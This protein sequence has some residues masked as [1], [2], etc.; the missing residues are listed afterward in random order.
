MY[1]YANIVQLTLKAAERVGTIYNLSMIRSGER[2]YRLYEVQRTLEA[3][4]NF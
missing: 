2:R 4:Q 1:D 3:Q